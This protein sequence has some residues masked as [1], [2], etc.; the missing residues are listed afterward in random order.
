ME[1]DTNLLRCGDLTMTISTVNTYTTQAQ[2]I[3]KNMTGSAEATSLN[4]E[5]ANQWVG[6]VLELD[7]VLGRQSGDTFT[8]TEANQLFISQVFDSNF[9]EAITVDELA[10]TLKAADQN[11]LPMAGVADTYELV[12]LKNEANLNYLRSIV[13]DNTEALDNI[14]NGT[15]SVTHVDDPVLSANLRQLPTVFTNEVAHGFLSEMALRSLETYR[16]ALGEEAGTQTFV[17]HL[18]SGQIGAIYTDEAEDG[19]T[20]H[21]LTFANSTLESLGQTASGRSIIQPLIHDTII[22][23]VDGQLMTEQTEQGTY[24]DW[25]F[26]FNLNTPEQREAEANTLLANVYPTIDTIVTSQLVTETRDALQHFLTTGDDTTLKTLLTGVK[27]D[28]AEQL[29]LT[30]IVLEFEDDPYSIGSAYYLPP[31]PTDTSSVPKIVINTHSFTVGEEASDVLGL[32]VSEDERLDRLTSQALDTVLH[33]LTHGYLDTGLT[34]GIT[35]D[36]A[37]NEDPAIRQAVQTLMESDQ[38]YMSLDAG[39]LHYNT[40]KDYEDNATEFPAYSI[41]S[42]VSELVTKHLYGE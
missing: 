21:Y 20:E 10:A 36:M 34:T 3:I 28:F 19:N 22:P 12:A 14:N 9:D 40:G 8:L 5:Q 4:Y 33:E 23:I 25:P 37:D 30:D 2:A 11:L 13:G 32:S 31:D 7:P 39:Y 16:S 41:G 42:Y 26:I 38:N 17:E 1:K 6:Q 18:A 24:Q 29:G 27:E 35:A 15:Y